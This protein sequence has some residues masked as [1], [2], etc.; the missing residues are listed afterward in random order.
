MART[1]ANQTFKKSDVIKATQMNEQAFEHWTDRRVIRLSGDDD[2][3]DGKGKPRRLGL[4]TI[5]K[6]AIAHRIARLGVPANTAVSLAAK[7]TDEPQCGR[8]IGCPFPI[9]KTIM[10]AT[11]DG[12]ALI[13]NVQPD[14]DMDSIMKCEAAIVVDLGAIVENLQLRLEVI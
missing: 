9:G 5:T 3:G 12:A 7:F 11:Q 4:R 6:L 1:K 2:P 14:S 13:H 8:N 10:T